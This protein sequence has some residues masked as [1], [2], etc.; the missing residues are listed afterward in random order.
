MKKIDDFLLI[1]EF[2][3]AQGIQPTVGMV[4]LDQDSWSDLVILA[5][6]WRALNEEAAETISPEELEMRRKHQEQQDRLEQERLLYH[7]SGHHP[8]RSDV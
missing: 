6:E 4:G 7:S 1:R 2:L 8:R 5:T 3:Q